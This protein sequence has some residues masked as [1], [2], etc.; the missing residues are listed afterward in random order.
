MHCCGVGSAVKMRDFH[1]STLLRQCTAASDLGLLARLWRSVRSLHRL[2][3]FFYELCI[4]YASC[5]Y[6]T[7][8]SATIVAEWNEL[9]NYVT[10]MYMRYSGSARRPVNWVCLQ[11][12]GG[13]C[14]HCTDYRFTVLNFAFFFK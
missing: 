3:V 4:S 1:V 2:T 14:V 11:A 5:P 9:S 6:L 10:F 8:I 13:R 7:G 12:C